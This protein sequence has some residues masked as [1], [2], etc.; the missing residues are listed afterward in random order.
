MLTIGQARSIFGGG[1]IQ[2]GI[3]TEYL[4]YLI[5]E[6][7]QSEQDILFVIKSEVGIFLNSPA[8]AEIIKAH[9]Y[10]QNHQDIE[11][12]KRVIRDKGVTYPM[13]FAENNKILDNQ[14]RRAVNQK[15][16]YI[17]GK[18]PTFT[19]DDTNY[20][21][22][23]Q[24][25]MNADFMRVLDEAVIDAIN[26]GYGY[27]YPYYD[28]D[29]KL[30]WKCFHTYEIVPFWHDDSRNDCDA[31][32]RMYAVP[33]YDGKVRKEEYHL[34]LYDQNGVRHYIV[35]GGNIVPDVNQTD[36]AY[37][38]INDQPFKWN[39]VPL[40]TIKRNFEGK[41]LLNQCK[42][43]QDA[44]NEIESSFMDNMKEDFRSTILVVKNYDGEDLSDF[45]RNLAQTGA[46][47]VKDVDGAHGGVEALSIE[48][49]KDNYEAILQMLRQAIIENC[50]SYDVRDN[51]LTSDANQM[52]IE[53]MFSD[54][55]LDANIMENQ[56]KAAFERIKFFVDF[57]INIKGLGDYFDT[58]LNVTFN[59]SMMIS[60]STVIQNLVA[61][62]G[63][64]SRKTIL[65]HHPYVSNVQKE[66]EQLQ[67]DQ[68]DADLYGDAF[69]D[70]QVESSLSASESGD[71]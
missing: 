48:V 47:K 42:S 66:M 61:S 50:F 39:K 3:Q 28:A 64:L 55:D 22:V 57:D 27:I 7:A 24:K 44:I 30:N 63:I 25:Y 13:P 16:N 65:E 45:R 19:S 17:V 54:V 32:V 31:F 68:K 18:P 10:Y 6:G 36:G 37:F 52:H 20:Q 34:D 71:S 29:G 69:P 33:V 67:Q 43:L 38:T 5:M 4:S 58:V 35:S 46:V 9:D 53:S 14:Y 21:A 23:F 56:F 12:K 62:E 60:E 40:I 11:R 41:P 2:P 70:Q 51:R 26:M 8:Y 59:R 1:P 49:N 15:A